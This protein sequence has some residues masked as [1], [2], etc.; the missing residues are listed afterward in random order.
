MPRR[1]GT[2]P[3]GNGPMT[4]RG[5]GY[6]NN[7]PTNK[8]NFFRLGNGRGLGYNVSP[9]SKEDLEQEKV[10]LKQRLEEIENTLK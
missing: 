4:G 9:M 5:M 10:L 2:G 3:V 1:N 6:C 7:G 8:A